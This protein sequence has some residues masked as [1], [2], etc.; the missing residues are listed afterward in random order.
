MGADSHC[1]Q[2]VRGVARLLG[3]VRNARVL[4][5]SHLIDLVIE[6]LV[7]LHQ[8]ACL[9]LWVTKVVR[10]RL[11]EVNSLLEEIP[12]TVTQIGGSKR[13]N[14]LESLRALILI[15]RRE[16]FTRLFKC[17]SVVCVFQNADT[18][19]RV[20][21]HSVERVR[22]NFILAEMTFGGCF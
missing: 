21:E 8:A 4:G 1:D 3:Q 2:I 15:C 14:G 16:I 20:F 10:G 5:L 17:N 18:V 7:K 13:A 19:R 9:G 12:G 22:S 6:L 11:A